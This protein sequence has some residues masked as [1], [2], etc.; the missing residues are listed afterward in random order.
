MKQIDNLEVLWCPKEGRRHRA[1]VIGW[2]RTVEGPVFEINGDHG[3]MTS[4]AYYRYWVVKLCED[5]DAVWM[6][7]REFVVGS[8]LES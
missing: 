3:S 5:C 4:P 6:E 2:E 8:R 1:R 7:E